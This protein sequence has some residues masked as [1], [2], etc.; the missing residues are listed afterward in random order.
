MDV[1]KSGKRIDISYPLCSLPKTIQPRLVIVG[2]GP[3]RQSWEVLAQKVYPNTEFT[4]AKHGA[5]LTPYFEQAD[6][7][8]LPGT[9][10][11]AVQ[12]A[13]AYGLPVI[14]AQGDGT[15]DD[16]VR[17]STTEL[18]G[19]GWI[20]PPD[21]I[22]ALTQCLQL[23]LSDVA[24]LRRKGMESYRIVATEANVES[25]VEVFIGAIKYISAASR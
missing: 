24:G 22:S 18:E 3:A 6:L 23:A 5:E 16:L 4:G 25:M 12:Q 10:G 1:C 21:D 20:V 15:Q 14:V 2:E 11:L 17:L 9:G 7:F 19:N 13:M 8:V